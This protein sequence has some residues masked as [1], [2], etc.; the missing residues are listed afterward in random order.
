MGS[1]WLDGQI[2]LPEK[3]IKLEYNKYLKKTKTKMDKP[4]NETKLIKVFK[5]MQK[6][7]ER[8]SILIFPQITKAW[9]GWIKY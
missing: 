2:F 7:V 5:V 1:P 8:K 9:K 4:N 6:V 3:K